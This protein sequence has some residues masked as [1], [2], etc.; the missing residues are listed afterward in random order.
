MSLT[1]YIEH[2]TEQLKQEYGYAARNRFEFRVTFFFGE[3]EKNTMKRTVS[4]ET[5][6]TCM[7]SG[8]MPETLSRVMKQAN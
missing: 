5:L 7:E 1:D 3:S 8:K 4:M 6:R 2:L